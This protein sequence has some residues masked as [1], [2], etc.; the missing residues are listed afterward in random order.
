MRFVKAQ[1]NGNDFV[2]LNENPEKFDKSTLIK[3]ADRKFGIGCDQLI[4]VNQKSDKYITTFFNNDGSYANMCGNG[5]CAVTKY[6]YD[7]LK[8][9]SKSINLTI[10]NKLYESFIARDF[11]SIMFELPNLQNNIVLHFSQ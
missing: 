8:I 10:D 7:I 3:I 1:T 2:I 6:I 5:A 4:F 9:K 11:I